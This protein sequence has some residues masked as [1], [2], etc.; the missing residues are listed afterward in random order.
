MIKAIFTDLDDTL[1]VNTVLYNNA[2]LMLYG[3]LRNFGITLNESEEAFNKI[4]KELFKEHGVSRTRYPASFE[5]TLKHFV[6]NADAE[7]VAIV[8][9]L[10]ETVFMT[11]AK[12]K[13]DVAEAVD[14]L[15]QHYPIY[16][17]TQG[18][19]SVQNFR[20]ENISFRDKLSGEFIRD[21]KDESV[22]KDVLNELGLKPEE[23]VMIGD[24]L[25]SD[26]NPAS[27]V[28]LSAIWIEANNWSLES[29]NQNLPEKA[30]KFASFNE[31]ARFLVE[32]GRIDNKLESKASPLK[33]AQARF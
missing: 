5:A 28:G 16:V 6:P 20:L 4:D 8:R 1:I 12:E 17:V 18:D 26:I 11:V 29:A 10:A 2:A 9:D 13:H 33:L 27:K 15:S 22:F 7:K 31:A 3:Y 25:R 14:L 21:K 24:S 30:V 19:K 32:H 23:V